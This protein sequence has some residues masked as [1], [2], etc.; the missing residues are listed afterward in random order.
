MART[1]DLFKLFHL[2]TPLL[3]T[4]N[5]Q[6]WRPFQNCSLEDPPTSADIWWTVKHI[7]FGSGRYASYWNT[8][9]LKMWK[10]SYTKCH[11]L[12]PFTSGK[13][14]LQS[15]IFGQLCYLTESKESVKIRT[16][17]LTVPISLTFI[18][19]YLRRFLLFISFKIWLCDKIFG[20]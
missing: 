14:F 17:H 4:F 16:S 9:L 12:E 18:C 15:C 6:G 10:S 13:Y 3:V 2:R 19:E 5:G 1:G 8:F 11:V 7:R 20:I